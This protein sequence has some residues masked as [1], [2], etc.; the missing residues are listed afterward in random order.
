ME[1]KPE[2]KEEILEIIDSK[3]MREYCK[4]TSAPWTAEKYV[5][6]I[7]GAPAAISRKVEL[8]EELLKA[9]VDSEDCRY[10]GACIHTAKTAMNRLLEM[11]GRAAV[12][13]VKSYDTEPLDMECMGVVP[14]SSYDGFLSYIRDEFPA[15]DETAQK[16]PDLREDFYFELELYDTFG[17]DP[18]GEEFLINTYRYTCASNGEVQFFERIGLPGRTGKRTRKNPHR[19]ERY[20]HLFSG[21]NALNCWRTPFEPGDI[22]YI[23]CRPYFRPAYCV[24]HYLNPE[25]PWDCCATRC[26]Y[27]TYGGMI[28]EAALKH[29]RFLVGGGCDINFEN[30]QFISPLYR[31]ECFHGTLPDEYAVLGE[32]SRQLKRNSN[33]GMEIDGM[34]FGDK[35]EARNVTFVYRM[36]PSEG[37]AD[38]DADRTK[39]IP[40]LSKEQIMKGRH[41]R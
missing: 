40:V 23:D 4:Q 15:A 13:L 26:L 33:L 27:L 9:S 41:R 28:G 34:F 38:L 7:S 20:D 21:R 2:L 11:D 22:L 1:I 6:L 17:E 36:V 39:T 29:G 18:Q 12:L 10:L 16:E 3:D 24:V 5:D 31:A 32:I 30:R 19:Q 25:M 35:R 14:V 8:L 37:K